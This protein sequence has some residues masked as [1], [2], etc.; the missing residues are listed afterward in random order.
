MRF[1]FEDYTL[2][3]DR[4]ELKRGQEAVPMTPQAFDLLV[5]LIRNRSRVISRDHLLESVWG[6]R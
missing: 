5:H 1:L 4:R 3:L 2:D 6:G